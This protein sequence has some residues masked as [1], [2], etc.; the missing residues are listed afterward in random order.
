MPNSQRFRA[1]ESRIAK[2]ATK[3]GMPIPR[4]RRLV[5]FA[6]LIETLAE[7]VAQGRIPIFFVK[8]GVAMELRLGL[9][10]RA[11]K[12][13]DIGLC[14]P[15]EEV[16]PAFDDALAI[17]YGD[18]RLRR[19]GEAT[20]LDNGARQLRVRIEYLEN[21]FATVD[22]DLASASTETD[23][24][25]IEPFVLA[26]LDLATPRVVPCLAINEQ[27]AQK[28]HAT[29]EPDPRG[30]QNARFRDIIDIL[31]LNDRLRP[32][33][34][35]L[36]AACERVFASRQTHPWPLTEHPFPPA[37][38]GPL[39]ALAQESGYDTVIVAEI[40]TRFNAFLNALSI[41]NGE[42]LQPRTG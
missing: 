42:R 31:L 20:V 9:A 2:A 4:Y 3:R 21:P 16:V 13:L 30:R 24:E 10:A 19:Q 40:Q 1:F 39:S 37:W 8:G 6:V 28:V 22:V 29:T 38:A 27:I 32:D 12:D 41:A 33:A 25:P 11:T 5:G 17:G 36:Y 15:P 35:E 7:A 23:T 14:L 26:E 34:A 18:F